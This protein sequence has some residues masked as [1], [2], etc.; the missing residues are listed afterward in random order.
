MIKTNI[1]FTI[2]ILILTSGCKQT[3]SNRNIVENSIELNSR[4]DTSNTINRSYIKKENNVQTKNIKQTEINID[5]NLIIEFLDQMIGKRYSG[6]GLVCS[7][8]LEIPTVM[9][10]YPHPKK[11]NGKPTI[12][13]YNQGIICSHFDSTE[14]QYL[15][16]QLIRV[17]KYKINSF[18]KLGKYKIINCDTL[19]NES[20]INEFSIPLFSK[21]KKT[22]IILYTD[23]ISNTAIS[24]KRLDIYKISE[25]NEWLFFKNILKENHD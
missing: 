25:T 9:F 21:N 12:Q 14:N 13:D 19:N 7:T 15:K 6:N 5:T 1:I 11:I 18:K 2:L 4:K 3:E 20:V 22:A 24:T 16:K 8:P 23:R 10:D 17:N